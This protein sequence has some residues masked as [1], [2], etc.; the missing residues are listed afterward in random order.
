MK[1][2]L[3]LVGV[4]LFLAVPVTEASAQTSF[5]PQVSLWDLSEL[6]IG[7]RV[8]FVLGDV[9]GQEEGPFSEMFATVDG[10][11]ILDDAEEVTTLAFNANA[12]VP[13]PMD[14]NLSPYAGAGLNHFRSSSDFGSIS[15]SGLN[16]LGGLFFDLGG[17]NAFGQLQYSTTGAGFL[18]LSGGVLF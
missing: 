18:T 9:F 7:A 2:C 14:G 1:R 17:M 8:D 13:L 3:L 12:A 10:S 4:A 16:L 15:F 11:Y 6:G 5:G